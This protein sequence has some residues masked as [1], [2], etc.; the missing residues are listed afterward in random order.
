VHKIQ[1]NGIVWKKTVPNFNI[2]RQ[3]NTDKGALKALQ[4]NYRGLPFQGFGRYSQGRSMD[5]T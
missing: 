4:K 1:F 2:K 3:E 5:E